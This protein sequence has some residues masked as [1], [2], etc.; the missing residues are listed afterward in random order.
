MSLDN[1][2]NERQQIAIFGLNGLLDNEPAQTDRADSATEH[3]AAD[4]AAQKASA[5]KRRN[6]YLERTTHRQTPANTVTTEDQLDSTMKVGGKS[7][8]R[9]TLLVMVVCIVSFFGF[10]QLY[11]ARLTSRLNNHRFAEDLL[12]TVADLF[13]EDLDLLEKAAAKATISLPQ[14]PRW[15]VSNNDW[16]FLLSSSTAI[17]S[18]AAARAGQ[19]E[20]TLRYLENSRLSLMS[21]DPTQPQ[22]GLIHR[23]AQARADFALLEL[24]GN[25]GQGLPKNR[26]AVEREAVDS[27]AA[28]VAELENAS[29]GTQAERQLLLAAAE[30]DLV[31]IDLKS[32][33]YRDN[34]LDYG[35]AESYLLSARSR[36]DAFEKNNS[37]WWTQYLRLEG[38]R[39]LLQ[40]RTQQGL[41]EAKQR[42]TAVAEISRLQELAATVNQYLS[43]PKQEDRYRNCIYFELGICFGNTADLLAALRPK[44]QIEYRPFEIRFREQ[45]LEHLNRVAHESRTVRHLENL[46]LNY[47]QLFFTSIEDALRDAEW[48]EQQ[49]VIR[50]RAIAFHTALGDAFQANVGQVRDSWRAALAIYLS[51]KSENQINAFLASPDTVVSPAHEEIIEDLR[52][53]VGE[54]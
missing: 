20:S 53:R 14:E 51:L 47:G 28:C 37:A 38:N 40:I 23:L 18:L 50:S 25:R 54:S 3:V 35:T 52:L 19:D 46:A 31:R 21:S 12:G 44:L 36:L 42:Q 41:S 48:E 13:C 4:Q 17:R 39:R 22:V 8:I 26:K 11:A 27:I 1:Y 7:A 32:R 6:E 2:E 10:Q 24:F 33:F 29:Y 15:P 16:Q 45:A 5:L 30:I 34:D 49:L 43:Q 9:S